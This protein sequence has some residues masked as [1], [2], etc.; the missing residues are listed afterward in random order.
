MVIFQSG[1]LFVRKH[2]SDTTN[3]H[4]PFGQVFHSPFPFGDRLLVWFRYLGSQNLPLEEKKD[5]W[6][7]RLSHFR[8][9]HST[10]RHSLNDKEP[11]IHDDKTT[12]IKTV[13]MFLSL[14]ASCFDLLQV[15]VHTQVNESVNSKQA[16]FAPKNLA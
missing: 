5:L 9:D 7:D 4:W 1:V 15:N 16:K 6:Q 13:V 12:L 8:G 14:T 2:R 11:V 3:R 10:C